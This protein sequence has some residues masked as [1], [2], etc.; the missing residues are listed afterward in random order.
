MA[1]GLEVIQKLSAHKGKVW[2]ASWHPSGNSN[3]LKIL[4]NSKKI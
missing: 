1:E 4:K 2:S 3:T